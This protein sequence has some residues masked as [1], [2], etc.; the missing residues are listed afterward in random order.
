MG[1][2]NFKSKIINSI[3]NL[4]SPRQV[5]DDNSQPPN[6]IGQNKEYSGINKIKTLTYQ[7]KIQYAFDNKEWLVTFLEKKK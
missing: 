1:Y 2:N 5:S 3:S 6:I 7:Q 4:K